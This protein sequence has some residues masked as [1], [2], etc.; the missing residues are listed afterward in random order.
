MHLNLGR[1][2]RFRP[3]VPMAVIATGRGG[4]QRDHAIGPATAAK[5]QRRRILP[6]VPAA[7]CPPPYQTWTPAFRMGPD[8]SRH[9]NMARLGRSARARER[10]ERALRSRKA[11]RRIPV[12]GVL[13]P[14]GA[15]LAMTAAAFATP[16]SA[17][18]PATH[19][20]PAGFQDW[21]E[22]IHDAKHTGSPR[23]RSFP[24][25]TSYQL[26]WSANTG[27][28]KAYS[29]PA[30]VFNPTLGNSLVYVGNQG[31][32]MNAYN[33]ATGTLVWQF[34]TAK[35]GGPSKEIESSPAVSNN[36]VYF[37]DGDWHEY[38]LN[39]TTGALSA[40]PQSH[41]RHHRVVAVIGNP[42]GHGDVVYFGDNGAQR[43]RQRPGWRP[44]LGDLRR[45]QHRRRG[46]RDEVVVRQLRQPAR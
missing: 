7:G 10:K 8:E 37:G 16:A 35:I 36:T 1:P 41:G 46:M 17:Q 33:A 22:H 26:H 40:D 39:A 27:G 23:R 21:P 19:A 28:A 12:V 31:G 15:M 3:A 5:D 44:S 24:S 32:E 13:L 34:Q 14:V 11:R 9:P 29:S 6:R 43:R 38:A 30:V 4:S 18:P 25:S 20:I 45:G 2:D 42:D